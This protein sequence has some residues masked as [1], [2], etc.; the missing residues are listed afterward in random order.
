MSILKHVC[1]LLNDFKLPVSYIKHIFEK[2]M[3]RLKDVVPSVDP[4]PRSENPSN[5]SR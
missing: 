2:S 5:V 4:S 1:N 3:K